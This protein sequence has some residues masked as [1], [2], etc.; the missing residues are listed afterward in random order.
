MTAPA[1]KF[2]AAA[3]LFVVNDV[4]KSVA[5]Y[6]DVLGFKVAFT[7]GQPVFYGGVERNDVVIHFQAASHT[8]RAVGQ[9]AVNI[10]VTEVDALYAEL[11]SRGALISQPPGDRPYGMR[12]FD[13]DDPDGNHLSFGMESAVA[14]SG[15][16]AGAD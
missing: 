1:S 12:D 5:H 7:Y 10:F 9:G 2:C 13:L 15:V 6:R 3:T 14:A 16:P 11:L 4:L 8:R